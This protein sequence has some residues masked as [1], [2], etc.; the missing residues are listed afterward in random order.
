MKLPE[1]TDKQ[2]KENLEK[3]RRKIEKDPLS[4]G[5]AEAAAPELILEDPD[6]L[7]RINKEL[8]K[9][10]V[11]EEATRKVI[12][13]VANGRNVANP[14][15]MASY[16]LMVNAESGAGK[17][18]ITSNTLDILPKYEVIKRRG[19]TRKVFTYWKGDKSEP[20]W[21][22]DKKVFYCEDIP[23]YILNEDV[24][25]VMAASGNAVSTV[26]INQKAVDIQIDGKP[27]MIITIA[28]ADPKSENL[29]RFPIVDVDESINQTR[30]IMKR[31]SE[32]AKE[33]KSLDYDPNITAALANLKRVKVKIPYA[34]LI[35][36]HFP[37]EHI[38]M[39]TNYA[40]FLDYIKSSCALHQK[41]R[42]K[43]K[44]GFFL[45]TAEDYEIARECL[46]KTI[47]SKNLI[48]INKNQRKIMAVV[49]ESDFK[50][51]FRVDDLAPKITFMGERALRNNLAKLTEIGYFTRDNE[52]V[53]G[54]PKPVMFFSFIDKSNFKIPDYDYITTNTSIETNTSTTS[55][56]SNSRV[57]EAKEVNETQIQ[58]DLLE[59]KCDN[60]GNLHHPRIECPK[61]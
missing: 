39:R 5:F 2:R 49:K 30:E 11:G 29:R 41:Q 31:Q 14:S 38:I 37:I 54:I 21:T 61:V 48:P 6:L 45:A 35:S 25:K 55:N 3:F 8:D 13:L 4:R 59:Y 58:G 23:N 40:R 32:Y 50:D 22:W 46:T 53:E 18:Y 7:N 27:S 16:N 12:L 19:I 26:V 57:N 36:N 56:T 24:F 20:E 28:E 33:G 60:C 42:K 44:L 10:I 47:S 1:I 51:N 34:D 52:K 43:D 17:D 9:K 15:E